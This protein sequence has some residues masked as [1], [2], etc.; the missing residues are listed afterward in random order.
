MK[1]AMAQINTVVGD[2][3]GNAAKILSWAGRAKAYGAD[4][5][6]FPEM[7]LTGYPVEDLLFYP[8]F[9]EKLASVESHLDL[10][11][12]C[13]G[14]VVVYGSVVP[15]HSVGKFKNIARI[16]THEILR[17][18]AKMELPN[19]GVFDERRYFMPG[20][21]S[22]IFKYG[23]K[24]IAVTICEDIWIKN[25]RV[26]SYIASQDVDL[27]LN[28]S[29]SPFYHGKLEVR[30]QVIRDFARSVN[31]PVVYCNLV[32]A[33]DE[34][35]FDGGSLVMSRQGVITSFLPRFEACM[36]TVD[37]FDE[38]PAT[39]VPQHHLKEVY[40]A[41]VMGVR[42]YVNKNGFKSALIG[43]SGGVDSALTA[44]IAVDALGKGNVACISM[45]SQ[46]NSQETQSDAVGQAEALGIFCQ[47]EPIKEILKTYEDQL[48][49]ESFCGPAGCKLTKE[50]LQARIRGNILM[51]FSNATGKIVLSTGNKSELSVGYCTL[52]GDMCGGFAVLKDVYKTMVFE[53]CRYV[54][55]VA[56]YERILGSIINRPPSAELSEGQKDSDSLPPYDVLDGIIKGYVE[57]HRGVSSLC[58]YYGP[59]VVEKV[60]KMLHKNE[61]KRRQSAPGVKITPVS[62]GKDRRVP[63][64][65]MYCWRL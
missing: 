14:I 16:V 4:V 9:M 20:S 48:D 61:Y 44:A 49:V 15:V 29:A 50:N 10:Q 64:S 53:L 62:F 42:D 32:G 37:P 22:I 28:L 6:V 12:S 55:E 45:P 39:I 54:N 3:E 17:E 31:A 21:G 58:Q 27:V 36:W 41:L 1:V 26:Q 34:L 23:D 47:V 51:A 5:V 52:Y 35:V 7:T 59:H 18:Y 57:E 63:I 60:L 25:G 46:F 19:Y 2:L 24:R 40:D 13:L 11:L 33:Q 38:T 65:N 30:H 43:M 8:D 56:G